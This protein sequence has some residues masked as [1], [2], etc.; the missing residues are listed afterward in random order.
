MPAAEGYLMVS[1]SNAAIKPS[2]CRGT[3]PE[4]RLSQDQAQPL[5][6]S[7]GHPS[8]HDE[9][10]KV[11]HNLSG[12]ELLDQL[13]LEFLSVPVITPQCDRPS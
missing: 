1:S 10:S 5:Q 3:L 7:T 13:V 12:S 11:F 6:C 8:L 9:L 4:G 2:A